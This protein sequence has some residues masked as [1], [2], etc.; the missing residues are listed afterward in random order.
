MTDIDE[1]SGEELD[2]AVALARGWVKY[3]GVWVTE[4]SSGRCW[5]E[6]VRGYHPSRDISQAWELADGEVAAGYTFR[7]E[8]CQDSCWASFDNW[9]WD[10]HH[11]AG[12]DTVATAISRVFLKAKSGVGK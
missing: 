6:E 5:H 11:A 12:G 4:T 1:L 10:I 8:R 9:A 3:I 7:V 2:E